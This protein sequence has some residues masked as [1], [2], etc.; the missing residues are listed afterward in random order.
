MSLS[1]VQIWQALQDNGIASTT[2]CRQWAAEIL[3]AAGS[4]ALENP[5]SL[6]AQLVQ[7]GRLTPYQ[8][9]A[10]L[11][12]STQRLTIGRHRLLTPLKSP[13]LCDWYEAIDT[14]SN[15]VRWLFAISDA[16]LKAPDLDRH[17]PSLKLAR[18]H[19][20]VRSTGLQSL[21]P[22]AMADGYLMVAATPADGQPL[23]NILSSHANRILPTP[24]AMKL[25]Q[26]MAD[27]LSALHRAGLVHGWI[28]IDQ[29]WWDG[30]DEITLLRDPFY[31]PTTPLGSVVPSSIGVVA[32][33]EFRVRYAAPEF[34]APGQC[35]TYATDVYSLGCLWWELLSGMPPY[36]DVALDLVPAA[37]CK[38][39]LVVPKDADLTE[40]QKKCLEHMLAKNPSSRFA[41][42]EQLMIALDALRS[43]RVPTLPS[44][45][46]P[47]VSSV[48]VAREPAPIQ[49]K[50]SVVPAKPSLKANP[51][52]MPTLQ[53]TTA[54]ERKPSSPS[55]P[56]SPP[57]EQ[58]TQPVTTA[59]QKPAT[60]T[61][62]PNA[63][64]R[65]EEKK[66]SVEE[67]VSEVAPPIVSDAPPIVSD[68]APP[69]DASPAIA[70][71]TIAQPTITQPTITQPPIAQPEIVQQAVAI[72]EKVDSVASASL[73]KP[74]KPA[75]KAGAARSTV[76]RPS[77]KKGRPVWLIPAMLGGCIAL[78][79]GLVG[80]LTWSG[81][82][83]K[84]NE[85]VATIPTVANGNAGQN[86]GAG[87]AVSN[88]SGGS[89]TPASATRARVVD[90]IEDEYMISKGDDSIPWVPPRASQPYSLAMLPPGAQGFIFVRPKTWLSSP[91][92]QAIVQSLASSIDTLWNPIGKVCG[93][94]LEAIRELT[95]GL[96]GGRTDGW[97]VLA[98]R[99]SLEEPTSF[100]KLQEKMS[101]ATVQVLAN[102]RSILVIGEQAIYLS[103][104]EDVS[105]SHKQAMTMGPA[106]LIRELAEMDG[107]APLRR[108]MEQLWQLSDAQ[109]DF[110][111]LLTTGFFFSDARNVLPSISP[112]VQSLCKA[113]FDEKTQALLITTSLEPQWY[114]ELRIVGQN[115]DDAVR[116]LKDLQTRMK[117][118]ADA[119][120]AELVAS[121]ASPYWRAIAA[122]FP[123]MLRSLG[124][125]QRFGVENNQAISNFY[126]PSMASANMTIA[127]WL[128]LTM[129]AGTSTS[130]TNVAQTPAQP[131]L[132]G[133]N[134]LAHPVSINFEQE[135]LDSALA[136]I[137]EEV[138]RSLPT[139]NPPIALSIDGKSFELASVTRNQQIR[140]FRFK[141]QPLRNLL[142]DLAARVNP[143]RTV[144][145]LGEV[146][147]AVVWILSEE[148][149]KANIIFT[150]RRGIEGTDRKLPKEFMNPDSP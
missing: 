65:Y 91:S 11:S 13:A 43:Q 93:I 50:P 131:M 7:Q 48:P 42:G 117:S 145:S 98:Y 31:P 148:N 25:V 73:L 78:L 99:A 24:I 76:R 150:T 104:P 66:T 138:N 41:T 36:A 113:M 71:P 115:G 8:A 49:P 75:A 101:G 21:S 77:K 85:I 60:A 116:F 107:G 12:N 144:N 88:T 3:S 17:P 127:T 33:R 109:S 111:L 100:T 80:I 118:I 110:S 46:Q 55:T 45:A 81:G 34:T 69:I 141:D 134:L 32:D 136:L 26:K 96:Y 18:Q 106:G 95:I 125:Y 139:G 4:A 146:K 2:D 108:Q 9:N 63:R 1:T 129:P 120:E 79:A 89:S 52:S 70:Q 23:R 39:P 27:A 20:T 61:N 6:L 58:S 149:G 132:T 51:V 53:S 37:A 123:Q 124:R 135:P 54:T 28:G 143:D 147:Q 47:S 59:V 121:P 40:G 122:R 64:P 130:S 74:T 68:A 67:V 5:S 90:P 38:V 62:D 105:E 16:R 142:T 82:D 35:P 92:G 128:S 44:I 102:Q 112:R 57:S 119:M 19:A 97:P 126:L 14:S 103:P 56:V 10:L 15:I 84:P 94:P 114:G 133:D 86:S 87:Q 72:P 22:P 140:D 83:A 137:T 30:K 29:V